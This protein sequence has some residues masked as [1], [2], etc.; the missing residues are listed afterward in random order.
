M[1]WCFPTVVMSTMVMLTM[2][3]EEEGEP[4]DDVMM[5]KDGAPK[6]VSWRIEGVQTL[7][8]PQDKDKDKQRQSVRKDIYR[9]EVG[10]QF[11]GKQVYYNDDDERVEPFWKEAQAYHDNDGGQIF[12]DLDNVS[13]EEEE[14]EE[15]EEENVFS[16]STSS[17][18]DL[19][20]GDL[21][22]GPNE[23]NHITKMM[24]DNKVKVAEKGIFQVLQDEKDENR[25]HNNQ[26]YYNPHAIKTKAMRRFIT[27]QAV[28]HR[29][30]QSN[31]KL[32]NKDD[33]TDLATGMAWFGGLNTFANTIPRECF[34]DANVDTYQFDV[35]I[36]GAGFDTAT[37]YK[38]GA[39]FGPRAIRLA[40]SRLGGGV[41]PVRGYLNRYFGGGGDNNNN[42]NDDD[43]D[44]LFMPMLDVYRYLNIIDCG[45]VPM[46]PFDNRI[47]LDQLYRGQ[48]LVH[49]YSVP[50]NDTGVIT[51]NIG[52]SNTTTSRPKVITLGGDHTISLMTIKAAYEVWGPVT[53]IHFDSHLDSWDPSV[54]GGGYSDYMAIN[55][56]TFL[57]FAAEKGYINNNSIHVGIRA[58][59]I[60][61]DHDLDHDRDCGFEVVYAREI[62]H[63]GIKGIIDR[64]KQRLYN[65]GDE[66]END[67]SNKFD[68]TPI[69]I[70]FDID[71]LD[72]VYAPGTGTEE[73]G[74]WTIREVLNIVDGLEGINLIGAD[75]VEVA[76]AY[77]TRAETTGLN[78]AQIVD[79]FLGLIAAYKWRRR[80]G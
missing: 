19:I 3:M 57:H 15:E 23:R 65:K 48:R 79:S 1:R 28:T 75:L 55:H 80:S 69:F 20:F 12:H 10:G 44:D 31:L 77:D 4:I 9:E 54:I 70:S 59:L 34:N 35:A 42:N 62:D 52:S 25:N 78:A 26:K 8:P 53:V 7:G 47:A 68:D 46:T 16:T 56:G 5:V 60:D 38:P 30:S 58:P 73:P 67:N 33:T 72:P 32:P 14:E 74:G 27:Q 43:D 61:S 50:K 6:S 29:M 37:S 13:P 11:F 76:P 49:K 2:T 71:V 63:V 18:M 21:V 39:R 45:D 24:A 40:S 36:V 17:L 22:N 51:S 41:L 66:N 64:V